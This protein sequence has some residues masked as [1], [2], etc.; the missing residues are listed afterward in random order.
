M[1]T[2]LGGGVLQWRDA[3]TVPGRT[4]PVHPRP[5]D[6]RGGGSDRSGD[7]GAPRGRPWPALPTVDLQASQKVSSVK[8][9]IRL[10]LPTPREPMMMTCSLKS[11]GLGGCLRR[12]AWP[13]DSAGEPAP[14]PPPPAGRLC[15]AAPGSMHACGPP[16]PRA[17]S[18]SAKRRGSA[19]GWASARSSGPGGPRAPRCSCAAGRPPASA[20]PPPLPPPGEEEGKQLLRSSGSSIPG[21]AARR[22]RR[23]WAGGGAG[24]GPPRAP[25]G[26]RRTARARLPL[27]ARA[28]CLASA[29][30]WPPCL[31][32]IFTFC[33]LHPHP[34]LFHPHPLL[35]FFPSP[36]PSVIECS[37]QTLGPCDSRLPQPVA[38]TLR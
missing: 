14:N 3:H 34:L 17:P 26:G 27:P 8:R 7:A 29:A 24:R 33:S 22:R 28:P 16:S 13:P 38:C 31:S 5:R 32:E 12:R 6:G 10:V 9:S 30:L 15:S 21:E 11:A 1:R 20:P 36:A 4:G 18:A 37:P 2:W 19:P 23:G 25:P 35:S